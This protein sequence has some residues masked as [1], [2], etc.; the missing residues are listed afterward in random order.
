MQKLKLDR[1]FDFQPM[2]APCFVSAHTFGALV[3][4][5]THLLPIERSEILIENALRIISGG[6]QA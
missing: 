1:I 2:P 5:R 6:T 4:I 3:F